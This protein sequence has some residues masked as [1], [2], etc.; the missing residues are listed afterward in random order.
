MKF[1]K[2]STALNAILAVQLIIMLILSATITKTISDRTRKSSIEHMS[3]IADERS[4]IIE[5]YVESAE[6]TLAAYSNAGEI[7]EV[8]THP[9]DSDALKKAQ[10]YTEN[11]SADV[12]NLEGIYVS[13]WNT[14]VLAHTNAKT[15]GMTTRTGDP[16]KALQESMLAAGNGVYDTGIIISP[17]SG[18]QIVSMY[19]AVYDKSGN[20]VGLV[21]L[22]VYTD[23]LVQTLD[24]LT[25]QGMENAS[26]SMVNV[27]NNQYIFNND[28]E[29]I[30][31]ETESSDIL[32]LCSK[33][34]NSKKS[35]TGYFEYKKSGEKYISIYSYMNKYG[36]ILMIDDTE[37][38][39]FALTKSM[40][41]YLLVF[42]IFCICLIV[43]FNFISK[44]QE[45]TAR[46][47]TSA[48]AKNTK[49][50]ESLATAIFNDILTDTNSR[51]SFSNDFEDG[52]VKNAPEYPYYFIMFNIN[53]FSN[54][55]IN[56][57]NDAGDIVLTSTAKILRTCFEGSKIYRTG[58]D[59][60]IVTTQMPNTANSYN[61]II[62]TINTALM[63]LSNPHATSAGAITVD[64]KVSVIKKSR[65][66]NASVI[67]ALKDII[68][69]NGVASPGHI[70]YVDLDSMNLR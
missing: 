21:G 44:K 50:K 60:F 62:N 34:N 48:V 17:A 67:A 5:N 24:N 7:L 25:M 6:S 42:C 27:A 49:T 69:R 28:K 33:Y 23:G 45:E 20:P 39:I 65:N 53:G 2:A 52:K 10:Q 70:N 61:K 16:L 57:G 31:T 46:K 37:N 14:H 3:T 8:V 22:G 35:D 38:E 63:Q 18:K 68:N 15:V 30:A 58:S 12:K 26:Y 54:V 51:V 56:Y 36:W 47:L 4:S 59:E 11:F 32:S 1:K 66:I 40:N 64:Y 29:K 41:I 43:F 13:E 55:N 9:T 19:K